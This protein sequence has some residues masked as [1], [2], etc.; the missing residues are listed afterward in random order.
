MQMKGANAGKIDAMLMLAHVFNKI[1]YA[2]K[3]IANIAALP[4]NAPAPS[5]RAS[6]SSNSFQP[7]SLEHFLP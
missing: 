2:S 6:S 4:I 3:R 7:R 5:R 1:K